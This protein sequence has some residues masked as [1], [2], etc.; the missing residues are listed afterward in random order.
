MLSKNLHAFRCDAE[1]RWMTI[2]RDSCIATNMLPIIDQEDVN[3]IISCEKSRDKNLCQKSR[4]SQGSSN[5]VKF[6]SHF[7]LIASIL[8]VF[9]SHTSSNSEKCTKLRESATPRICIAWFMIK[10]PVHTISVISPSQNMAANGEF[11]NMRD[12][13][14]AMDKCSSRHTCPI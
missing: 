5:S 14:H 12:L 6:C 3:K 13:M 1:N 2:T 8:F 10:M 9:V 7:E 4:H 11:A